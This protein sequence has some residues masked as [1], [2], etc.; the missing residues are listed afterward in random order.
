MQKVAG[1]ADT[2][3]IFWR[4]KFQGWTLFVLQNIG[5]QDK[6]IQKKVRLPGKINQGVFTPE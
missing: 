4:D 1:I 2:A 3:F 5:I 6:I